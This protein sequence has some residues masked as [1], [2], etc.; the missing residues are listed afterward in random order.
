S[1]VF[2]ND[3]EHETF[4]V[5]GDHGWTPEQS[6]FLR[7]VVIRHDAD[8]LIESWMQAPCAAIVDATTESPTGRQMLEHLQM[9]AMAGVPIRRHDAILGVAVAGFRDE[10]PRDVQGLLERSAAIA[11]QAATALENA[12]LLEQVRHQATHDD[13]TGLPNRVLFED[14]AER[15]L[16]HSERSQEPVALLFVDLDGF[17]SVNDNL[18]HDAGDALLSEVARRL[19]AGLRAGDVVARLGGDEF[20]A[21]LPA[22]DAETA[23][24]VAERLRE[25]LA[26]PILLPDGAVRVSACIGIAVSPEDANDYKLL[27][28]AADAA[29]YDAKRLGR[30]RCVRFEAA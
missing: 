5:R 27:L 21:L 13:L 1:F 20:T 2:L 28:K 7:A 18:G 9:K 25:A 12:R 26:H 19:E 29:M 22:T 6:E 10:V 4:V 3:P 30:D 8:E 23:A 14:A 15:A 17:K 11:D 24:E 16:R